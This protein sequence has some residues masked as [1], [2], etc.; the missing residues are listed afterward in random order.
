M[1]V[2]CEYLNT[3]KTEALPKFNIVEDYRV[4][5]RIP[6]LHLTL[7]VY[8]SYIHNATRTGKIEIHSCYEERY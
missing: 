7:D 2:K 5:Y 1:D 8:R 3:Q 4:F 6:D